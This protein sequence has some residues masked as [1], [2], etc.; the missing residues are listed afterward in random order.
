MCLDRAT[1]TLSNETRCHAKWDIIRKDWADIPF[2]TCF[3]QS[4]CSASLLVMTSW[5]SAILQLKD[6]LIESSKRESKPIPAHIRKVEHSVRASA[7]VT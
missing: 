2:S 3:V 4:Q 6:C 7:S 1:E 5:F